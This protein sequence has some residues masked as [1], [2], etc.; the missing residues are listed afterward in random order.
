MVQSGWPFQKWEAQKSDYQRFNRIVSGGRIVS[1]IMLM[2][3]VDESEREGI[4]RN[5]T[6]FINNLRKKH[7]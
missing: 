7:K 1:E 3:G 2:C 6:A 4:S 5:H